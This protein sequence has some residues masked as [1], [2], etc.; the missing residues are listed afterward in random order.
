MNSANDQ[1][2]SSPSGSLNLGDPAK[3]RRGA[4]T[5][6]YALLA[7]LIAAVIVLAVQQLGASACTTFSKLG[8]TI[9]AD[10]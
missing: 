10:R 9:G 3:D 6:E 7:V 1:K 2:N 5:I 8:S 4:T